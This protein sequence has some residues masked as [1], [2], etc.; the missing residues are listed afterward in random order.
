M[1][2]NYHNIDKYFL[3]SDYVISNYLH[4]I[5]SPITDE[6]NDGY[7]KTSKDMWKDSSRYSKYKDELENINNKEKRNDVSLEEQDV[8]ENKLDKTDV[9]EKK[10]NEYKEKH[11]TKDKDS[12]DTKDKGRTESDNMKNKKESVK[13]APPRKDGRYNSKTGW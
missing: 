9:V 7:E 3:F 5:N 13:Y 10:N 2:G 12:I 1:Y 8:V 4:L 6:Y 11:N